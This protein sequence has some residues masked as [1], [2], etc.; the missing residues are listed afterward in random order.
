MSNHGSHTGST[1]DWTM[2]NPADGKGGEPTYTPAEWQTWATLQAQRMQQMQAVIQQQQAQM[3]AAASAPQV[4]VQLPIP[5]GGVAPA[6]GQP[7]LPASSAQQPQALDPQQQLMHQ[8]QI[9]QQLLT[10]QQQQMTQLPQRVRKLDTPTLPDPSKGFRTFE[11]A[12]DEHVAA[13][14]GQPDYAMAKSLK[15]ALPEH[16]G[17]LASEKFSIDEMKAPGSLNRIMDWLR[18]RFDDLPDDTTTQTMTDWHNFRRSGS[19]LRAY[20]DQFEHHLVRMTKIGQKV[21]AEDQKLYLLLKADLPT[22]IEHEIRTALHRVSRALGQLTYEYKDL[23]TELLLLSRRPELLQR[24]VNASSLVDDD[25]AAQRLLDRAGRTLD[26]DGSSRNRQ[27]DQRV[28]QTAGIRTLTDRLRSVNINKGKG[29]G[30]GP[31]W[32][33]QEGRCL[34]GRDCK[35]SHDGKGGGGSAWIGAERGRDRSRSGFR[36]RD[37]SRTPRQGDRSRSPRGEICRQ[38]QTGFC[39][40]GNSCR[41]SHAGGR[42]G[43]RSPSKGKGKGKFGKARSRSPSWPSRSGR[44]AP[45]RSPRPPPKR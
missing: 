14:D 25:L 42:D 32:H 3:A 27:H 39:N 12:V 38:Y 37:R 13:N 5:G 18:E 7:N 8:L 11:R 22:A 44:G 21:S 41:F 16:L 9:N 1:P 26:R 2:L 28:A 15:D 23:K 20:V 17:V 30:K 10:H 40:F 31:C 35:F 6:L 43:P 24:R 29:K 34:Y 33:Y 19:D 36:G 45:D 4:A